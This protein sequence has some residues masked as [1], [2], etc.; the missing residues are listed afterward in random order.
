MKPEHLASVPLSAQSSYL[1]NP[2]RESSPSW[3]VLVVTCDSVSPATDNLI[4]TRSR[5]QDPKGRNYRTICQ[6]PWN[7]YILRIKLL[8]EPTS[9]SHS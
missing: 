6:R 5:P 9:T 1:R 4:A 8:G 7:S 3:K 2:L